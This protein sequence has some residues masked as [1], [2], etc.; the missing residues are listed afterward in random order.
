MESPK[1]SSEI[2]V[3]NTIKTREMNLKLSKQF[4]LSTVVSLLVCAS[5]AVQA[6]EFTPVELEVSIK[7]GGVR[8]GKSGTTLKVTADNEIAGWHNYKPGLALRVFGE[9][10]YVQNSTLE[11][12]AEG[13][14]TKK[15]TIEGGKEKSTNVRFDWSNRTLNFQDGSTLPMPDHE[16]YDLLGWYVSLMLTPPESLAGKT[17]SIIEEQTVFDYDYG[18]VEI[19]IAK[20][21]DEEVSAY[22]V[23]LQNRDKEDD[24]YVIWLAPEYRNLPVKMKRFKYQTSANIVMKKLEWLD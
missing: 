9:R 14:R 3:A 11:L 4:V 19:D 12:T 24:A 21:F 7:L 22:R 16:I 15:F 10:K 5:L 6:A 13:V 17:I 8:V 23:R 1:I 2:S 18:L 20:I